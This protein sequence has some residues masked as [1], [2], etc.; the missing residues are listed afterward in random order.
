MIRACFRGWS[1]AGE[2]IF[3]CS[4]LSGLE[5]E[6]ERGLHGLL[7]DLKVFFRIEVVCVC[8]SVC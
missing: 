8:V 5:R 6:E 4:F 1:A 7:R 3:T 2:M